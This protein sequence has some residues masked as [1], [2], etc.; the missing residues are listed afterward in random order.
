M[1]CISL[2]KLE[3]VPTEEKLVVRAL[4]LLE[5]RQFWAGVV[6]LVDEPTGDEFPTLQPHIKYKIRMDI[7]Y[8][9]PTHKI[10]DRF[11]DPGPEALTIRDLQYIWGGFVYIQDLVE[12]AI[13]RVQTNEHKRTGLYLQQMP[14]PCYVDD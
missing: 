1:V 5:E 12:Q 14:Y 4:Q 8:V 9:A 3:A 7:D 2:N 11:W 13:I 10:K 6:F